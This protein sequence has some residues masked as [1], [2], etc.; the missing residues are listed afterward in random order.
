LVRDIERAKEE[1]KLHQQKLEAER[2]AKLEQIEREEALKKELAE[3]ERQQQL[4]KQRELA[5][6]K[7]FEQKDKIWK[8]RLSQRELNLAKNKGSERGKKDKGLE[9]KIKKIQG[10][11]KKTMQF[12]KHCKNTPALIKEMRRLKLGPYLDEVVKHLT[13]ASISEK[14]EVDHL[15]HLASALHQRFEQ[16]FT[17]P[18]KEGILDAF[19]PKL[20]LTD[21]NVRARQK[22]NLVMLIEMQYLGLLKG[23]SRLHDLLK[24]VIRIESKHKTKLKDNLKQSRAAEKAKLKG[25][26][27]ADRGEEEVKANNYKMEDS[28][29]RSEITSM[30][31]EYDVVMIHTLE[32]LTSFTKYANEE[33]LGQISSSQRVHFE[34]AGRECVATQHGILSEKHRV[35]LQEVVASYFSRICDKYLALDLKLRRQRKMNSIVLLE[36]GSVSDARTEITAKLERVVEGLRTNILL[37]CEYLPETMEQ[38]KE[39]ELEDEGVTLEIDGRITSLQDAQN[40][41]F[42]DDEVSRSFYEK[43]PQL[44]DN[45]PGSLLQ[46]DVIKNFKRDSLS[47]DGAQ[48]EAEGG[49][50]D[51]V[52]ISSMPSHLVHN[53]DVVD[54]AAMEALL[55]DDGRTRNGEDLGRKKKG[56]ASMKELLEAMQC[57]GTRAETEQLAERFCYLNSKN[58]RK[59]LASFLSRVGGDRDQSTRLPFYAR[60]IAILNLCSI[61]IG[62]RVC[63]SLEREFYRLFFKANKQWLLDAKMANLSYIAEMVKFSIFPFHAMFSILEKLGKKFSNE[64]IELLSFFMFQC[65]RF[66]YKNPLTHYR[67]NKILQYLRRRQATTNLDALLTQHIN[68]AVFAC[69]PPEKSALSVVALTPLQQYIEQL[70]YFRLNHSN[71]QSVLRKLRKLPWDDE[72]T[73]RFVTD[74]LFN[75]GVVQFDRLECIAAIIQGLNCYHP[76]SQLVVDHVLEEIRLGLEEEDFSQEQR[77]LSFVKFLGELYAFKAVSSQLVMDTLYLIITFNIDEGDR[78]LLAL[79]LSLCCMLLE[80][81]GRYLRKGLLKQRCDRFLLYLQ[82]FI[83]L[84]SPFPLEVE[85]WVAD[86]FEFVAP[87]MERCHELDAILERI[88]EKEEADEGHR[89]ELMVLDDDD[90]DEEEDDDEEDDDD[91][92]DDDDGDDEEEEDDDFEDEEGSDEEDAFEEG[93]DDEFESDDDTAD[94]N[95]YQRKKVVTKHDEQFIDEYERMMEQFRAPTTRKTSINNLKHASVLA[96]TLR[97]GGAKKER[98]RERDCGRDSDRE[99]G[100]EH[101]LSGDEAEGDG[102]ENGHHPEE[103]DTVAFK[104]LTKKGAHSNRLKVGV[105]NIPKQVIEAMKS[106]QKKGPDKVKEVTLQR[107]H[108]YEVNDEAA[109]GDGGNLSA[110][111]LSEDS[112]IAEYEMVGANNAVAAPSAS[113]HHKKKVVHHSLSAKRKY[114]KNIRMMQHQRAEDEREKQ[115]DQRNEKRKKHSQMATVTQDF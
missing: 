19:R 78:T 101:S 21:S 43:L 108:E 83:A 14:A 76:V 22:L 41:S 35:P 60:C 87:N 55:T 90:E 109:R 112:D 50:I 96:D 92:D 9:T 105:L 27:A 33:L 30:I 53:D 42:F 95:S 107:L 32:L 39:L 20:D 52:D 61:N 4:Q 44:R 91:D 16:K 3:I 81:C 111:D 1:A 99:H 62:D 63:L 75:V 71:K 114:Y 57:M 104:L 73:A 93:D 40:A 68:N 98:D 46:G 23:G 94:V 113:K 66:L 24:H 18:F 97:A 106:H 115:K 70:L 31:V 65:G 64:S 110:D 72:E 80:T 29:N 25:H 10:F 28:K 74:R 103:R 37:F 58:N 85:W 8:H 88:R 11:L 49:D 5:A 12:E 79:R 13:T 6:D 34:V 2:Q 67:L 54:E 86:V 51:A 59:C 84:H 77:R 100:R 45:I 17:K 36:R 82:R 69:K 7:Y 89:D 26:T 102:A 56:A 38:P 47:A 48:P 15:L